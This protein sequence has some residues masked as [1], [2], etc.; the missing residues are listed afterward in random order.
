[1]VFEQTRRQVAAL[2]VTKGDILDALTRWHMEGVARA[3]ATMKVR[4]LDD[5]RS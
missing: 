4:E 1:M 3:V 5:E 2:F